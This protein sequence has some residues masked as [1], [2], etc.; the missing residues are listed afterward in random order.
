MEPRRVVTMALTVAAV[1]EGADGIDE[2][3]HFAHLH[4]HIAVDAAWQFVSEQA[5][6]HLMTERTA[7][8]LGETNAV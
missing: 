5:E 1:D 7:G 4:W 2:L 6:V 8:D 3:A